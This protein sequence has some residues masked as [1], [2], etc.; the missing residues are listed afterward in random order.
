VLFFLSDLFFVNA[1]AALDQWTKCRL[2]AASW[3]LSWHEL[4][5]A[6][7]HFTHSLNFVHTLVCIML[8]QFIFLLLFLMAFKLSHPW[9][10]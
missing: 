7:H 9:Q 1:Q 3:N 10:N 2:A 6:K 8:N 4:N 5:L